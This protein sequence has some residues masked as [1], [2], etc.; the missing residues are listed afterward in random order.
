MGRGRRFRPVWYGV[1]GALVLMFPAKTEI[2]CRSCQLAAGEWRPRQQ[3]LVLL[4]LKMD[5]PDSLLQAT[6]SR[7]EVTGDFGASSAAGDWEQPESGEP[8]E[9]RTAAAAAASRRR[10]STSGFSF[11]DALGKLAQLGSTLSRGKVQ[12]LEF[13]DG[14]PASARPV[15]AEA[16]LKRRGRRS[17]GGKGAESGAPRAELRWNKEERRAASPRQ[18]ELKLTSS[19]FALTG[20]SAHNQAMVHWSGQNSSCF[21]DTGQKCILHLPGLRCSVPFVGAGERTRNAV[22]AS[23]FLSG[24]TQQP[25][26]V[27]AS[28]AS[29]VVIGQAPVSRLLGPH[30]F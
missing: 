11:N 10:R 14:G 24:V 3:Q 12:K 17:S 9:G 22:D 1:F 26:Q 28:V 21:F 16:Q 30:Q 5:T 13:P 6:G 7:G 27:D 18:E 23:A 19:T 29:P 2:S 25:Q 20:D 8:E 15:S 4:K